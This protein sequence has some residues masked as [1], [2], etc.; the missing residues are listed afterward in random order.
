MERPQRLR[1]PITSRVA[2]SC[3]GCMLF[4]VG[5]SSP[6]NPCKYFC[7]ASVQVVRHHKG[8]W[9]WFPVQWHGEDT[10]TCDEKFWTVSSHCVTGV[11]CM[12]SK[13]DFLD[14]AML[15]LT[16]AA[17][18]NSCRPLDRLISTRGTIAMFEMWGNEAIAVAGSLNLPV[19]QMDAAPLVSQQQRV[20]SMHN[21][22]SKSASLCSCTGCSQ[23]TL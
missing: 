4:N 21:A 11:V 17:G 22:F 3:I 20:P 8:S 10:A 19:R 7:K 14:S 12:K 13:R 5:V 23:Y 9:G 2:T 18:H 16:A 15:G 6:T 1:A